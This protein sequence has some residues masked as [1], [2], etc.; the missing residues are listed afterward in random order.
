[1]RYQ[2]S[3]LDLD[4]TLEIEFESTFPYKIVSWQESYTGLGGK[5]LTTK[6]ELKE[7]IQI[8]YWQHNSSADSTYRKLLGL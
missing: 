8:A 4:R 7:N 2:V 5:K 1:Y 6:A 3:Y